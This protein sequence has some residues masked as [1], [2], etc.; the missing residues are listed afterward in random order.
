MQRLLEADTRKI[1]ITT[2][3]KFAETD[4]CIN[5]LSNIIVMMDEAHRTQEGNLDRQMRHT[6]PNVFLFGLTGTPINKRDRNAFLAFGA[7]ED[8]QGY[9]NRYSFQD[10]I[11]DRATLPLH[12]E[13]VDVR[14]RIDRAAI[15]E[16]YTNLT[17]T[18]EGEDRDDLAKRAARM[19][20][21]IK[22]PAR[23]CA[24][25]ENIVQ[26][27]QNKVKP[28]GFKAQVI[29]FDRECCV[30]YKN[31]LDELVGPEASTIVMH[32]HGGKSDDYAKWKLSKDAE[33]KLL[34]RFRDPLDPL[35]FLIVT[36]KLLTDFDAPILQVMYLDKPMKDHNLLQAICR[37]NRVYAEKTHGLIVDYLGVFDEIGTALDFDDQ[38]IKKLSQIWK[39]L[40]KSCPNMSRS[41]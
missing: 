32:T 38:S 40:K 20:V 37:T 2:I 31:I 23:V 10:P 26:H 3:Y 36:S 41:A 9:M 30:L 12:F 25:C 6:L 18:L 28:N 16:T 14:L 13:A 19:S 22:V 24:I 21:L 4:S 34:D 29:T 17:D 27:F 33:E 1:I 8:E 15:D 35:K 5:D 39:S 11:R 7:E